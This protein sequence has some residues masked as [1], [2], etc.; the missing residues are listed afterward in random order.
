[1]LAAAL[2]SMV[3]GS[4]APAASFNASNPKTC[5]FV[6]G[7]AKSTTERQLG[8]IFASFGQLVDVQVRRRAYKPAWLFCSNGLA[9]HAAAAVGMLLAL[10]SDA[11]H[12]Q[13]RL[14][15]A[16]PQNSK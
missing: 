6:K 13:R 15:R 5:L 3:S 16:R 2:S 14:Y 1:M 9:W 10:E 8:L 12:E 11:S 4:A 7:L